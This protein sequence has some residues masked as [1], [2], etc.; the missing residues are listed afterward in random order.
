MT[1]PCQQTDAGR[2]AFCRASF[3]KQPSE[4]VDAHFQSG[5]CSA[6][7]SC[8]LAKPRGDWRTEERWLQPRREHELL[9]MYLDD[10]EDDEAEDGA[11]ADGK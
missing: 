1:P 3:E 4:L 2:C 5:A 9:L 8:R 11:S 7:Q 10:E 6:I